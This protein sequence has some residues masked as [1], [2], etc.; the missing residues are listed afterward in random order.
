VN[1]VNPG[2][3]YVDRSN[4]M[5]LRFTKIVRI[6]GARATASVDLYN[7]FNSNDVLSVNN[8]YATWL[9][10]QSILSPRWA[11]VVLQYEF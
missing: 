6:G 10:P 5:Q 2:T 8:A 11:K 9:R 3:L 7:V 4:S 1:I